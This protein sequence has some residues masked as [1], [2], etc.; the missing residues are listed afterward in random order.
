MEAASFQIVDDDIRL[1]LRITP[2][3]RKP[4]FE[5]DMPDADGRPLS[6]LKVRAKP[7][8]GAANDDVVRTIAE[9]V[10]RPPSS[11]IIEAG[12]TARIKTV[13]IRGEAQAVARRLK[14]ILNP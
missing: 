7:Q 5:S 9:A 1:R 13:R 11:V 3:A 6:R 2:G 4:G 12:H 8:D 10:G 14:E